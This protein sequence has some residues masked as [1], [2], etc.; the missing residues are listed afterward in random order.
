MNTNGETADLMVRE[1]IQI[2]ESALKLAGL[3][4][5]NLAALLIALANDNPKL[6]GKTNLKRLISD[7]E[8]LAMFSVKADDLKGFQKESRKYG[9]LYYPIVNKVEHTGTVEIMA[10]AKDAMQINRVFE[11]MGYPAPVKEE[12]PAKKDDPRAPSENSSRERGIGA[13]ASTEPEMAKTEQR[14]S[15]KGRLAALEAAS[16]AQQAAAPAKDAA[17]VIPGKSAPTR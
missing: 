17:K 5:K 13:R 6:A 7:G 3:G 12:T 2:T 11:I 8:Q 15:V 4:A 9:F 16:K 1:S 14:P 10:K